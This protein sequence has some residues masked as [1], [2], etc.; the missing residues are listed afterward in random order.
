MNIMNVTKALANKVVELEKKNLT[1]VL[2][3][4]F[5]EPHS[6]DFSRE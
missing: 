1:S 3:K 5:H 6:R 2:K 4:F